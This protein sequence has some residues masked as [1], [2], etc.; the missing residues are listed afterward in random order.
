ME[1]TSSV[2]DWLS[3][4][5]L[6]LRNGRQGDSG[7]VARHS[8]FTIHIL[9][10]LPRGANTLVGCRPAVRHHNLIPHMSL[11]HGRTQRYALRATSFSTADKGVTKAKRGMRARAR[12]GTGRLP[13]VT[14]RLTALLKQHGAEL[15][16]HTCTAHSLAVHPRAR[17]PSCPAGAR[18]AHA[19]VVPRH[20]SVPPCARHALA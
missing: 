16:H 11:M 9:T 6:G 15:S 7:R 12:V 5:P 20:G 4:V 10:Q 1:D 18:G 17:H 3:P 13:A 2:M 8:T 19:L 14:P